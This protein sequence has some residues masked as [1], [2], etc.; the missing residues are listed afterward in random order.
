MHLGGETKKGFTLIELSI[1][2]LFI[3][4]L[5]LAVVLIISNTISSYQ[6]GLVLNRV[7]STGTS[8]ADDMRESIQ[9]SSARSLL[10]NCNILVTDSA[11]QACYNDN[12]YYF[13]SVT[14]YSDN[15]SA[16]P[17]WGAFCTGTYTY[18]WNTGYFEN[19]NNTIAGQRIRIVYREGNNT[20]IYKDSNNNSDFR[21]IK[22]K[23][24]TRSFCKVKMD[25]NNEIYGISNNKLN[26]EF[27]V[28][29]IGNGAIGEVVDL[30]PN[31]S[32]NDLVLYD[33]SVAKP[34]ISL[35]G[36]NVFYTIS[37]ILGT[38]SGNADIKASGNYCGTPEGGKETSDYCAINKFSFS[39]QVNGG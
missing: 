19:A 39:V 1:S 12:A 22:I 29:T 18:L 16:L 33:L 8:L 3:G 36:D 2:M 7:N 9:S 26:S 4:L 20:V 34:A 6:R 13:V 14:K 27:N 30:L 24:D 35:L 31:D 23:D 10:S 17:I 32:G 28:G 5:S 15:D 38:S 25:S 11:R 21:L 37:F